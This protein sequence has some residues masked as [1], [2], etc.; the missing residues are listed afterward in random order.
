M[1][2]RLP[3]IPTTVCGSHG[4]PSWVHLVREAAEAGRLGPVD[5]QEAYDDAVRVAMRDQLEAG[6]E[7]ISDGEMRRVT[8]IRGF[9][10]RM[11]GIRPLPVP[12]RLGPLNYDTHCPYEVVDRVTA[13]DGLGIVDEFRF[14][15]PHA[16]RLLRVAVP[17]PM[18]LL[19]PLRRG[20]PYATE[21]TLIADLV[22]LVNREI[23]AL[24][25]AGCEFVQVDE[26]NYVMGAGK[27]RVLKGDAGPMV[28]ALNATLEGVTVKVA[29][30]VCFGNAHNN[31][32]ATPRRY[33]GLYPRILDARVGQFV[34]EYANREMSEIDLWS[35][36]PSDKEV[37]VGVIDVKAFRVETPEEVADR[38]RLALKHVPAE[39]LWL[40]PDCGLWETP[41]WVGISK[42]RSM[43]EAARVL[44]RELGAG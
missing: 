26:P 3:L 32:F 10:D 40:V 17:G 2:A 24:V 41:R 34:F 14:A 6:V 11:T 19:M 8:F 39:R 18:T 5:L 23:R 43:V 31:S 28:E 1:R 42:L 44:R 27:H 25:A 29:L 9:Y 4:L 33:R 16:E 37:A 20:G 21:D 12:R 38:A 30:H 35:E 36:F 22:A 13:P 15:R 7:V